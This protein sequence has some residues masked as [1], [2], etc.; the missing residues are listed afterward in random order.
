MRLLL[1]M[2]LL[3]FTNAIYSQVTVNELKKLGTKKK[4]V[5]DSNG[6]K[7]K[8]FYTLN[9]NQSSQTG[10]GAGSDNFLLGINSLLNKAVHHKKGKYTFDAY[11]DF[12][13]GLVYTSS[14]K[15]FRKTIDRF[16]LTVDLEHSIGKNTHF[17]YGLLGNVNTQLFSTHNF[18]SDYHEKISN[19][20]SPGR[21]LLSLGVD[22]KNEKPESYFSIFATPATIRWITKLDQD[23]YPNKKFGVD[24]FHRVYTEIGAFISMHYTKYFSKKSTFTSRLDLFSN[25]KRNPE[26]IDVI[27]TNL[28]S[29][30]ISK[31]FSFSLTLDL[32]YDEDV[33]KSLRVQ[34]VSGLGL[35]LK[36]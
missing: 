9:V 27:F 32:F 11:L 17:T 6:W 18:L 2:L 14:Y 22:Y 19:F 8:G 28:F 36:I 30:G 24:S 13:L 29:L 31:N 20:L 26:K 3:L 15:K 5:L 16:D 23:F 34:Q 25:Y 10:S 1:F 33:T 4:V 12:E 35:K 7:R 21:A